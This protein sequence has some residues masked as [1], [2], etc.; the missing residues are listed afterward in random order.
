[1]LIRHRPAH[2]AACA[3]AL[4]V[5]LALSP[6]VPAISAEQAT[7]PRLK[8]FVSVDMEGLTGVATAADVNPTGRDYELFRTIMAAETNAAIAGAV[9]AGATMVVVRDSHGSK[10]NL[11]PGDLTSP[12]ARLIRGASTGPK[13]MMEG[14]DETFDAVVFIGYHARAGTPNAVLAHTSNGNVVDFSINGVSLPEAGYNALVAGLYKVPVVFASGD[15]AFIQQARALLGDIEVLSTKT[16]IGGAISGLVPASAED[17]IRAGVTLG[18]NNR[19]RMKPFTL[20][21]PY[22]MVLKVKADKPLYPGATRTGTG[23]ATF[24]HSDLLEILNAFN[25]MK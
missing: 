5:A 9:R 10:V 16:E 20:T 22:T 13:N 23:E 2:G 7:R 12:L 25:A 11:R 18:V 3:I 15:F 8:V 19:A 1:M 24:T 17:L 4:A 21:P 6:A 14:I